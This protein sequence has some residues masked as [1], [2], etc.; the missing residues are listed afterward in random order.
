M[1]LNIKFT[2]QVKE[3]SI[4][5]LVSMDKGLQVIFHSENIPEAMK[6]AQLDPKELVKVKFGKYEAFAI[7][8]NVSKTNMVKDNM[9]R[10]IVVL[11]MPPAEIANVAGLGILG[12]DK[13]VEIEYN[14]S[15]K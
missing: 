11:S 2:A 13:E 10:A 5:N 14:V 12:I 15:S 7:V 6:L 8:K 3:V 1:N 9:N 4:K